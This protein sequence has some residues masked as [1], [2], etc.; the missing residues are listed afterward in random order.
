MVGRSHWNV[1]NQ[2]AIYEYI[3]IYQ[4]NFTWHFPSRL[5]DGDIK[6]EGSLKRA[7]ELKDKCN[8][9]VVKSEIKYRNICGR[10]NN[11]QTSCKKK[12]Y[13]CFI[14]CLLNINTLNNIISQLIDGLGTYVGICII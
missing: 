8:W 7:T 1:C 2:C 11:S 12:Y 5:D 4:R 14:K 13:Q 6:H 10:I 3:L 9:V